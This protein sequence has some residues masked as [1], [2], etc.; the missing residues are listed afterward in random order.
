M[1]KDCRDKS[2]EMLSYSVV[3]QAKAALVWLY[4][5]KNL[6]ISKPCLE[7]FAAFSKGYKKRVARARKEGTMKSKFG[8]DVMSVETFRVLMHHAWIAPSCFYSVLYLNTTWV[9]MS[10]S[11][12]V[13]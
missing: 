5:K 9:L 11:S 12:T 3:E 4:K 13:A 1:G 8:K 10:R 7:A 2:G 6:T